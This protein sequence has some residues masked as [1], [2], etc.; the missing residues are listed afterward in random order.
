MD[1]EEEECSSLHLLLAG[2]PPRK[3]SGFVWYQD[4]HQQVPTKAFQIQVP[5]RMWRLSQK[6]LR[7]LI[8]IWTPAGPHSH[9]LISRLG[10]RMLQWARPGHIP[11]LAKEGRGGTVL[12]VHGLRLQNRDKFPRNVYCSIKT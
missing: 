5:R 7:N 6:S 4:V 2:H 9:V 11:I 8:V 12:S 3:A 10:R 1:M